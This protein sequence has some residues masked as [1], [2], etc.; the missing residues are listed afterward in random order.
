MTLE[1]TIS[2]SSFPRPEADV[3]Y[4][5]RMGKSTAVDTRPILRAESYDSED[6][7]GI[8]GGDMI[9]GWSWTF[10]AERDFTLRLLYL[11]EGRS[12]YPLFVYLHPEVGAKVH[13]SWVL[14]DGSERGAI[15][16]PGSTADLRHWW[17]DG[18]I[19]EATQQNG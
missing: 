8:V 12:E 18:W 3:R 5:Q 4:D 2:V 13:L 17:A 11:R 7:Y 6:G 16:E 19:I 10:N 1:V 15:L 9:P 14:A